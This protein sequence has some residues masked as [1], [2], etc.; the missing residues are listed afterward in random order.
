MKANRS[1]GSKVI[2]T[3]AKFMFDTKLTTSPRTEWIFNK[4]KNMISRKQCWHDKN[5]KL[6][7]ITNIPG[8][9]AMLMRQTFI[10]NGQIKI[11]T[12]ENAIFMKIDAKLFSKQ[13]QH[14]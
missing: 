13:A 7:L 8:R 2:Q 10:K 5:H 1:N 6:F 9:C 12:I 11:F 14:T 4:N 3:Q